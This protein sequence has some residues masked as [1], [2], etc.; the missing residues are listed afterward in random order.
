MEDIAGKSIRILVIE[1]SEDDLHLIIR[2]LEKGGY[3]VS[4]LRVESHEAFRSALEQ[5]P[6]DLVISDYTLPRFGGMAAFRMLQEQG[7]DIPFIIVS[8]STGEDA[9]VEAMKAGVHDYIM[10]SNL[11]R[12]APAVEHELKD[13]EERRKRKRAE[14]ALRMSEATYREIF[15]AAN[16][17]IFVHHIETGDILDVNRR[18][19]EMYGYTIEEAR[20]L[21]VE[22]LSSGVSPFNQETA[23][24]LVRRAAAGEPQLFEWYAKDKN[25]RLFW[26]EVNLKKAMIAGEE[27]VLAVV[28]DISERKRAEEALRESEERY[29]S[30]FYRV[31]I[32][33]FHYDLDLRITDCNDRFVEIL[34]SDRELLVGLDMTTLEDHSVLPA[35]RSIL[36]G[37]D[38]YYEGPYRAS[39]SGAHI[40]VKLRTVPLTGADGSIV[41][42]VGIVEDVTEQRKAEEAL[43]ES[44]ARLKRIADNMLDMI[45]Q[46]DTEGRFT[47]LSPSNKTTLGYDP[48]EL[49]GRSIM[50]LVHPEDLPHVYE[51]YRSAGES[52][53]PGKAIF[54]YRHADGHYIWVE[55]VGNPLTDEEGNVI[56]AIFGTRDITEQKRMQDKLNR[57]NQTLLALGV[58]PH[59]NLQRLILAAREIMEGDL[60]I[61]CRLGEKE[62]VESIFAAAET[63][64]LPPDRIKEA[65][66]SHPVLGRKDAPLFVDDLEIEEYRDLHPHIHL[67]QIKSYIGF[68]VKSREGI[69]GHLC[70]F[71][72][73]AKKFTLHDMDLVG[74]IS[75]AIVSEEERLA[76][77]KSLRDFID[78]ASHEL[79]H[80]ITIMKGYAETLLGYRQRIDEKKLEEILRAI[81]KGSNRLDKLVSELL[82]TSRIDRG[83]F[84]I[85]KREVKVKA[86]LEE[87]LDEV[88][89]KSAGHRFSLKVDEAVD[90]CWLDPDRVR[91]VMVI[92]LENAVNYSPEG[93]LIEIE[94]EVDLKRVEEGPGRRV[95]LS[96]LDRGMGIPEEDREKVFERFY[97]VGEVMHHSVPG[98][99][100]GLYIARQIAEA[101]GGR[102]W[103]EHRPGGGSIFRFTIPCSPG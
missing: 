85:A 62:M 39:T 29:R 24:R 19:E 34:Q 78:I 26:V 48:E 91:Q 71:S 40:W 25:G 100:L 12:L 99:G 46:I 86:I 58:D 88:R 83:K 52:L 27:R 90:T 67:Y 23:L 80:P 42:G 13:A 76:R 75:R 57:L 101:H 60:A 2:E 3:K 35:I 103:H 59:N 44:E 89:E 72:R 45:S 94:A 87:A 6:W 82:D 32:G 7:L 81:V 92:L 20:S 79:R 53:R 37:S 51:V 16:Y 63:N 64:T 18:M 77:E 1:D 65:I 66:C 10:K 28:R 84:E 98:I 8:G 31:P 17:A 47:Y 56:G 41:G 68:P 61:Y 22:D 49:M 15:N 50:E 97:Q 21:K 38:G 102:I 55:S 36:D 93:S 14:E 73:S 95:V 30:L 43:R 96:V 74:M 5:E 4:Y 33:V 54:R 9:A 11:D 69:Y 70:L